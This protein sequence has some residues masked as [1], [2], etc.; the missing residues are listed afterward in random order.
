VDNHGPQSP[1]DL[2]RVRRTV[3]QGAPDA[4]LVF[5]Q[6]GDFYDSLLENPEQLDGLPVV[7]YDLADTW[8]HGVGSMPREV[9]RVR[10][11]RHKLLELEVI[12]TL[13]DWP[14]E[15]NSHSAEFVLSRGIAPEIDAAY[16]QLLLFGEHTWGL[17]VKS[18]IVRIFDE[19]FSAA[20][21]T[22]PYRRLE[23]S[24]AAK[25]DYVTKSEEAYA[26]A[27]ATV[28]AAWHNEFER[29]GQTR[30]QDALWQQFNQEF[31]E[32]QVK[33]AG[34]GEDGEASEE[35]VFIP[36]PIPAGKNVLE[37]DSLR[38]EVDPASG[39]VT[40]Y[41]DVAAGREWVASTD[42]PFAGYRYDLYSAADIA[43][44]LRAYGL[45]FQDWFVH[46]F[47][48]PGYPEDMPH[49]T[50]YA[51]NF[52][53]SRVRDAG[54]EAILLT[55]GGLEAS[56]PG[57][58]RLPIQRVSIRL[59]VHDGFGYYNTEVRKSYSWRSL[60]LEYA[61]KG[62][63]A[64]PLAESTVVPFPLALP[65]ASFR[66]GQVGSVIDPARDIA[67]G[68]NRH[69]W[70]VDGWVD[71]SDDRVGMAVMPLDM[72][73]VSI[74]SPGIFAF[75]PARV[76]SQPTIYA[77]LSNTQWGTNFPQWLEGDFKFRVRLSPHA[78]DWRTGELW[79]QTSSLDLNELHIQGERGVGVMPSF[80]ERDTGLLLLSLH[81]AHAGGGLVARYW[82]ALGTHRKVVVSLPRPVA[83][84]WLCDLMERPIE[85][86]PLRDQPMKAR[87][88]KPQSWGMLNVAPHA[89]VTLL[90]EFDK[91]QEAAP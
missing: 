62:K 14:S 5:G 60:D 65:K 89:L 19:G 43:E 10:S 87:L 55:G 47:G 23:A 40:S 3:E 20:R 39:S 83:R 34:A 90:L 86:L 71:A 30:E 84:A 22:D 9:A 67:E 37:T 74:G 25:A 16:E 61:V 45:F 69:L 18:T 33:P 6:L 80:V 35:V 57:G 2:L 78:G 70:C 4:E 58:P 38:I 53:L 26:R 1:E 73:L 64:T 46:D 31:E 68:A 59:S 32:H 49:T 51:R 36:P 56:T 24:W 7:P 50:G 27:Y 28:L 77:H 63:E 42:E 66:L 82:D 72:P 76:P 15:D 8:I 75:D 54:G 91:P 79:G 52:S 44:F 29:L 81:P 21:L 88:R 17:D 48:R 85:A 41:I 12:A 11:L 13:L